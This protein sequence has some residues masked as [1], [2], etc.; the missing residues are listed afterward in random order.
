MSRLEFTRIILRDFKEYRGKHVVDLSS[1]GNGVHYV[2]GRNRVDALGSNGAGKSTLWDAFMWTLTGRTVRGLRGI[3]VRTWQGNEQAMC[4]VD[5]YRG[6]K[7]HF[8]RRSTAKNGLWLNG[9]LASQEEIDRLIGL[10]II[11]IPHTILLGQ[12]RDLFFDMRP[13]HKLELLSETLQLDKWEV[14]SKR[15]KDAATELDAVREGII[16]KRQVLEDMR[17]SFKVML[18][19]TKAKSTAWNAEH[20]NAASARE[21]RIEGLTKSLEGA[22]T[23]KG[24]HDLAYDGAETE[25]R[26]IRK[27]LIK[28]RSAM[29]D[30][31][32]DIS[33]ARTKRDTR[34]G[35]YD[36]LRALAGSDT[37]PT[38]G[39]A[40]TRAHAH[41]ARARDA[42]KEA[43]HLAAVASDRVIVHETKKE[44]LRDVIV[45]ISKAEANFAE[46][47][48]NAKDKLDHLEKHCRD[49][50][51]QIAVLKAESMEQ[52]N[53]YSEQL[54]SARADIKKFKAQIVEHT[55]QVERLD[56]RIVRTR[57]WVKGFKQLR[58]YLLQETL[59]ELEE[60]TQNLL[61]EFGLPGWSVE[62]DIERDTKKGAVSTGLS[63][64][65][66]KPGMK[67][68]VRWEAWSGGEGQRLLIV[69]AMALSE[70]LLRR[71]GIECDLLVLDEP[72]RHMSKEG[73]LETVDYLI[74]RGR[75][76]Q[77]FYVD[78]QVIESNRFASVITI[79]KDEHGAQIKV[80]A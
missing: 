25:L 6:N 70:V 50:Q 13:Q 54:T 77:I 73:V 32:E 61:P 45:R 24:T 18:E 48:D 56:R 78:H 68:A 79:T 71:A 69:G 53:P 65:I 8:V 80:A 76:A 49:I 34:K 15:A 37:C 16:G 30:I 20:G 2:R 42:L 1:L 26:A 44:L 27:D 28:K 67:K 14:R 41:A 40:V 33:K 55:E 43:K 4:R 3:D 46:K 60:V 35:R 7:P 9:K 38:C 19:E 72:T 59:E 39:Q 66:L 64:K 17:D 22:V 63:V 57:Y 10:S 62:Y 51:E 31:L 11:N 74:T 75:D 47:S 23:E 5:F 12:K 21:R 58:L 29:D 36:E 52:A